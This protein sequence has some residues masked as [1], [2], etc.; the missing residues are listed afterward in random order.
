MP[1]R[2]VSQQGCEELEH[3]AFHDSQRFA[4][5]FLRGFEKIITLIL[6]LT[7]Q[8]AIQVASNGNPD[9][10]VFEPLT[11]ADREVLA[12][13]RAIFDEMME[14]TKGNLKLGGEYMQYHVL[15]DIVLGGKLFLAPV[16]APRNILDQGTSTGQWV[17]VV[18]DLYPEAR[19][20]SPIQPLFVPSNSQ[21]EIGD[22]E[23]SGQAWCRDPESYD[24]VHCC[25][26]NAFSDRDERHFLDESY[27]C[28]IPGGW[29]EI[30][31]IDLFPSAELQQHF[32]KA[33]FINVTVLSQPLP[34]GPWPKE[35]KMK[36]IG[37]WQA[38]VIADSLSSFSLA[39]FT[40]Y[41]DWSVEQV[42][43]LVEEVRRGQENRSFH[44]H[45]PFFVVYG[46]KPEH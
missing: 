14:S 38:S 22:F 31:D 6:R 36:E 8:R 28:L 17:F 32:E 15:T 16:K 9:Q 40:K 23:C 35:P 34:I 10:R 30:K 43:K 26:G 46:Q 7:G 45:W 24:L 4:K 39:I 29:V 37:M 3:M 25:L 44:W 11:K 33:G 18:A 42:E 2:K 12:T 5:A 21:F 41:L 27:K 20:L 19:D 1:G 13:G